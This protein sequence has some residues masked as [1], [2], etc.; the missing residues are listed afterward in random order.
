MSWGTGHLAVEEALQ[1]GQSE[2]AVLGCGA[3]GLATARLLQKKGFQ[4]T[5]YA[6]DLP[7]RTTSNVAPASWSPSA[8]A[9]PDKRTPIK[10]QLTAV[11]PQPEVDYIFVGGGLYMM[12]RKDAI[13]LGG[14][15]ERDEWSME[16]SP[17]EM[18]RV[19]T[20]HMEFFGKM[21]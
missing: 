7:P 12:P 15:H 9:D 18:Q 14:T 16:P 21:A 20:G 5:I 13:L 6:K 3:V 10:G 17:T 8:S 4:P 11:L 19:M 1:T 2:F